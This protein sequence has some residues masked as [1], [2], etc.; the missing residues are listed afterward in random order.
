MFAVDYEGG[1]REVLYC[2]VT[3]GSL[4]MNIL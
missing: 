4:L 3:K 1:R 2:I